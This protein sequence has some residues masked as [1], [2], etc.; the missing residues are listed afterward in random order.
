[1]NRVVRSLSVLLPALV[2]SFAGAA[3][4]SRQAGIEIRPDDAGRFVYTDDYST[5]RV[6]LEAFVENAGPEI[7]EPGKLAGAGPHRNRTA[8][9]RFYGALPLTALSI[10]VEQ[11]AN[12]RNWG[13]TNTMYLSRNGLDW[14]RVA[15]SRPL[16]ADSGGWQR[17]AFEVTLDDCPD[18][19]GS[20]EFWVRLVLDNHSGLETVTCGTV[21]SIEI[22]VEVAS[23]S[24][25]TVDPQSALRAAWGAIRQDVAWHTLSID[26]A[27]PPE[28]RPPHYYEDVDRLLVT[29][30]DRPQ[31]AID[32]TGGF[33]IRKIHS[34]DIRPATGFAVFVETGDAP[35]PIM[36]CVTLRAGATGF[37][38][39]RVSWDGAEA[40]VLD[41]AGYWAEDR[42]FFVRIDGPVEAGVHEL[43]LVPDDT[44]EAVVRRIS[45]AGRP[46]L[47]WTPRP[48]LPDGGAL[49]VVSAYYMPDP[50]PSRDS[51]TVEGRKKPETDDISPGVGL[52]FE[53]MQR[54]V[55]EYADFGALRIV[56]RNAGDVP[57]RIDG[58]VLLN[59]VPVEDAY[60][61]FIEDDWDARGVVWYRVR[62]WALEPGDCGQVYIRF[63]R[64]PEGTAAEVTLSL[65][66]GRPL[67]VTVPYDPLPVTVDYVTPGP[68]GDTLYVYARRDPSLQVAP[69]SGL[70]LDGVPL[71]DVHVFGED[72][73]GGVALGVARLPAPLEPG[74]FHIA[75]VHTADGR[76]T[77][78][79][80]RVVPFMF[81]RSSVHVPPELCPPMHMNVATWYARSLAECETHG[82]HT[83]TMHHDVFGVHPRVAYTIAP[84]EPDASD[85]PGGGYDR[86][87]GYN[88]RRLA[89]S[90]WQE[91]VER[92]NHPVPS[93]MNI[94]GTVRPLNW[95]VYGQYGDINGFDPYPINF[96]G[97][98]HAYLRESLDLVRRCGAPTRL[99]VFL[100]T[101]GWS[102]GQG[103]PR[104]ARGPTRAEYRQN[105]VQSIGTGMK[106]LSSWV[107]SSIAGGWQLD[108]DFAEEITLMNR[109]IE[110]IEE[111]LLLGTPVDL[112]V[113]DAGTV[114]TGTVDEALW[115]KDRV[116]VGTLLCGPDTLVVAVANHI[117]AS[118]P[119]PPVI[120]PARDVTVSVRLPGFLPRVT[121]SEVTPDGI[122]PYE[123][124]VVDGQALL[125]LDELDSG[126][127]F[128]LDRDK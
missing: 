6:L 94:N 68:T 116:W 77:A 86:G 96:Y 97:A 66:N 49:E 109:L 78:A 81:P 55:D 89:Q 2:A 43:R 124:Q 10:R 102:S 24:A 23:E 63:R 25:E 33:P 58:P 67:E 107:Y 8:T 29:A 62:P 126:R 84:D 75:G 79:Q 93:W 48:P 100:E 53:K 121:A 74:A 9:Y 46:V 32:D 88:A 28:C 117:P 98:D 4:A 51:Q 82:I 106:G 37:R 61:D 44:G 128:L 114:L 120:E 91:L 47:R 69:V 20:P 36:A 105:V 103:V 3:P 56:Y 127:V 95:A 16:E 122:G 64:R 13:S 45:M 18:L 60:V 104:G 54:I 118:K 76:V 59:G 87:L 57:V 92:F 108:P 50:R 26:C 40:A 70:S 72:Y 52:T 71:A 27:E 90:G 115:P 125:F 83:S 12:A 42:D 1:M 123:C 35:G 17:S 39:M 110:H 112:G 85:N 22:S 119:E 41:T 34:R 65:E 14:T 15:E 21:E 111:P 31:M 80:F 19:E 11:S 38:R 113:A 30:A 7:W 5:P 99:F 101:F 73:P